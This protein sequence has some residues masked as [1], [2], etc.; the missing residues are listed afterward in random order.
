MGSKF[1]I[2]NYATKSLEGY[3]DIDYFKYD[4]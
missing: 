2:F 1:D 4:K 3:I